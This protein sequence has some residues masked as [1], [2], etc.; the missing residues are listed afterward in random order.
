MG[1]LFFGGFSFSDSV[2]FMSIVGI[3]LGLCTGCF[4]VFLVQ[5]TCTYLSSLFVSVEG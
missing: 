3:L 1:S 4:S 2:P 5:Y